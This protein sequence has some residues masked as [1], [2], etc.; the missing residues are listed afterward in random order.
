MTVA[1]PGVVSNVGKQVGVQ[2]VA[3]TGTFNNVGSQIGVQMGRKKRA[4]QFNNWGSQIGQQSSRGYGGGFGGFGL[5]GTMNMNGKFWVLLYP[6]FVTFRTESIL[7]LRTL[8]PSIQYHQ[9]AS[10]QLAKSVHD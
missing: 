4:A 10:H 6:F 3:T 8:S 5:P 7:R 2:N 1:T 9:L